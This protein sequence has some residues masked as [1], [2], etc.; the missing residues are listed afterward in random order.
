MERKG[1]KKDMAGLMTKTLAGFAF[2]TFLI[3]FICSSYDVTFTHVIHTIDVILEES[4]TYKSAKQY[5]TS[6]WDATWQEVSIPSRK[7]EHIQ[8]IK[9]E[10][11]VAAGGKHIFTKEQLHFFD[12]TRDSKP[13][14]LAILGRV[15]NVN[16][17]KEYYGP[18][19][20]YHHFAG[21]DAT[22]AFTTGDFTENGLVAT[23]H[24]L[25]HDELLSIRDWVSFYEKEYPLVGVVADLYY[26]SEGQPTDELTSVLA[27]IEKANEY[28]K[29]QAVEIEVFPPCNSE[30]NQNGG[31]VWCSTK[32]GG[33]ERQWAGVPRKLL[34]PNTKEYRCACVKNFGPGVS[35]AEEVK[36]STNRGDLDHPDLKVALSGVLTNVK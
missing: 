25:S 26:D 6:S 28:R 14:Y 12:G 30:Y 36:V 15:Y 34:E 18:G 27:R 13:C 35:G 16:G 17:K 11:D 21:R 32:S 19:K 1:R 31:R 24:G 22:R 20:S 23:T 5:M 4:E 3:A 9:P 8:A 2:L 33:V 10:V 7:A 29:A